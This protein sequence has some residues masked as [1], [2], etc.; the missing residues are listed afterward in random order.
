MRP[1]LDLL[2]LV[3][4]NDR[5]E[6][7]TADYRRL[8]SRLR[9][10]RIHGTGGLSGSA[11]RAAHET[12][13]LEAV[14][15]LVLE[16]ESAEQ[17]Q[18][19]KQEQEQE[20]EQGL[21]KKKESGKA[22]ERVSN[23]IG[24]GSALSWK[25]VEKFLTAIDEDYSGG[26]RFSNFV[27]LVDF[28]RRAEDDPTLVPQMRQQINHAAA[29]AAAALLEL[30]SSSS[31]AGNRPLENGSK[32]KLARLRQQQEQQQDLS[33]KLVEA[34]AKTTR[35]EQENRRL[36]AELAAARRG[37]ARAVAVTQRPRH[38]Q[39]PQSP[40]TRMRPLDPESPSPPPNDRSDTLLLGSPLDS[41][42]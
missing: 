6:A 36:Q 8:R 27:M 28:L 5:V 7:L 19:R 16:W 24:G 18:E 42:H 11:E 9:D 1:V 41:A 26:L 35:L 17:E 10:R 13:F 12:S 15:A 3:A 20:Q 34:Y 31:A 14:A 29:G 25:D 32:G 30:P 4:N 33:A 21:E 23:G 38:G 40:P 22:G 2:P 39:K 37:S